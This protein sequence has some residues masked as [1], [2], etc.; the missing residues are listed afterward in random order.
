M[1]KEALQYIVGLNKPEV[2]EVNGHSYTD[3]ELDRIEPVVI[4]EQDPV[5]LNTLT[6][7][8][9]CIK[10]R[11]KRDKA[12][13]YGNLYLHIKTPTYIVAYEKAS[14]I[15]GEITYICEAKAELPEVSYGYYYDSESFNILLQSRFCQDDTTAKLLG[16]VGN[17]KSSE[18]QTNSD[19]GITQTVKTSKGIVLKEDT[20]LP[21]PVTLAPFRT[22][23]EI[24]QVASAFIFRATTSRNPLSDDD[25]K[26]ICFALFEADGGAWKIEA[27]QRIKAYLEKAFEN[28]GIVILA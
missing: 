19:N 7:F 1:I 27:T 13:D 22:F 8:V 20:A 4:R 12:Y 17:V 11:V 26:D 15:D 16:I 21:N 18:I 14:S 5:H 25:S 24:D 6:S 9:D 2:I 28:T 23:V 3:K 10:S